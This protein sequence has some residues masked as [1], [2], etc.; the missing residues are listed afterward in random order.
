MEIQGKV[1]AVLPERSGVSARGE[2]KSQTYVIETQEQYPKKMAFDVFGADRIASFGIHS[3]EV[4]NVSFDIDAHEYQGRYF[5]QIRA[6]NVTKVSQQ[7]AAQ[8]GGYCG[9]VQSGAQAAQQAMASS[10]N[11]AGVANPTNQQN[12]FPPAQQS[13]QQQGDSS[14]LPF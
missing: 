3:G 14:D 8:G 2:W 1:I 12:L 6:W 7:A 11:A 5:N 10:A 4:I 9:N 13:A